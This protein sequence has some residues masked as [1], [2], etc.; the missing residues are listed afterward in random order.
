LARLRLKLLEFKHP[1]S[2]PPYERPG[3][4][5]ARVRWGVPE[6]GTSGKGDHFFETELLR[7]ACICLGE[8]VHI[9]FRVSVWTWHGRPIACLLLVS[10]GNF[11]GSFEESALPIIFFRCDH[12][13]MRMGAKNRGR[14]Q[15]VIC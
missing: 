5:L 13:N 2:I 6:A 14:T 1:R 10:H 11:A 7:G 15:R 8:F 9:D 4:M 3:L 12:E